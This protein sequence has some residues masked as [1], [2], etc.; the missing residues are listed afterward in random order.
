MDEG[1]PRPP[2]RG[3]YWDPQELEFNLALRESWRRRGMVLTPENVYRLRWWDGE[4]WTEKTQRNRYLRGVSGL[5]WFVGPATRFW[6]MTPER[7]RRGWIIWSVGM[8]LA[9]VVAL[10][11]M[12]AK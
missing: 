9:A 2:K 7:N 8:V 3:W 4:R 5:P 12:L 10:V 1:T 6:P 11:S